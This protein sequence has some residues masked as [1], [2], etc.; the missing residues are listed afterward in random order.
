MHFDPMRRVSTHE[1]ADGVAL[2][3]ELRNGSIQH[4]ARESFDVQVGHAE[5]P[6]IR[7]NSGTATK[8]TFR[9]SVSVHPG[10]C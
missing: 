3:H 7:A 10:T 8:E 1:G 9:N 6:S 2:F 5:V 4:C